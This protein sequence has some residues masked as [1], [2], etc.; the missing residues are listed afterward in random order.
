MD[1]ES[2]PIEWMTVPDAAERLGV[3]ASRVRG[4]LKERRL[5]AVRRGERSVLSIPV[6]LLRD[7]VPVKGLHGTLV[8]LDDFGYSDEEMVHWLFSPEDALG[9]LT[10]AAALQDNRPTAVHKAAQLRAI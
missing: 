2:L 7:G 6:A 3:D 9:G 10:P 5:V 4:M 8:M 1:L